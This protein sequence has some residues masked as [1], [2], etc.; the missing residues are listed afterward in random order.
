MAVDV[1]AKNIRAKSP[2][3]IPILWQLL[4]T[5]A[6][7]AVGAI[8]AI[9]I[10][11]YRV[12][13]DSLR[14]QAL[15]QLETV[16]DNKVRE[17]QRYLTNL[18]D[19]IVSLARNPSTALA[20]KQFAGATRDLDNDAL[21]DPEHLRFHI[22][23]LKQFL[24]QNVD[25]S[26]KKAG[27]ASAW[28]PTQRSAVYLQS[29]YI[30]NNPNPRGK[31]LLLESA[32][33]STRYSS[34]HSVWQPVFS[35]TI[36]RFH[37]EDLY[38]I[39][40][41][42][43]RVVYSVGKNPDFQANLADGVFADSPLGRL[44]RRL[45][46]EARE[47]DYLIADF[48]PYVIANGKAAAFAGAPIFENG[49]KTG[50]LVVQWSIDEIN[51][52]MTADGQWQSA[53]LGKTGE[54][55]IVGRAPND[56]LMRSE[57][58][59]VSDLLANNTAVATLH[60]AVLAQKIETE[61]V[62]GEATKKGHVGLY[63]GYT[64]MPV[65]GA[66]APLTG[67]PGLDWLVVA[68]ISE[69]EALEPVAHLRSLTLWLAAALIGSFLVVALIVSASISRPARAMASVVEELQKGNHR[70]RVNVKAYNELG[71][72]AAGLNQ[73]L[74]E[75]VDTLVKSEEEHRRLQK[76][77]RDLLTV[78]AAA[79]DGDFTQ[80]AVVGSGSLGNLADALNLMFENVGALIHHL[81]GVSSRVVEAATQI[82]TSSDHLAEG[83]A[84]QTEDITTTTAA[85]HGMTVKI[86][87]V[88][89]DAKIATEAARQTE[90]VAQ[91]GGDV[92]KRVT[93]G[94]DALQ[95]NT[96]ASA[97]KIKRLGERSME[98]STITATIQKISAQTNMLALNAAIEASRAG[99]HGLGFTVVADE[100]RKLA[101]QTEDATRE[102]AELIA[103]IQ[104]ETN[105]A[106]GGIE[107]Q[108]GYVEEQTHLV[109]E[110]GGSLKNI[111]KTS[112]QSAQLIS[113]ISRATIEQAQ[114]AAAVN[115]AMQRISQV[116]RE[117]QSVSEQQQQSAA[118]LNDV[119][120]ELDTQ[121]GLFRVPEGSTPVEKDSP[122]PATP[123]GA[124]TGNGHAV[125]H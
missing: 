19:Q 70:A 58:R 64:A 20:V 35:N 69:A 8:A 108:A 12:A 3:R 74:S 110:A 119:A 47:G 104:A 27:A 65:L 86:Q 44:F 120:T 30:A 114:S 21:T 43:G 16:R 75:R 83:G 73:A 62:V 116:A 60:T 117:T 32:K 36:A 81:H 42:S 102:I 11:S 2:L 46:T 72:L 98:I 18:E 113:E 85:V 103:S 94:M 97:V 34:Y 125:A 10:V 49:Q 95:K 68:E 24:Q 88:Q 59:F 78:V 31:R 17:L 67:V 99:E 55:Y 76:E 77:I 71:V 80:R 87:S 25:S 96:R 9:S 28:L 53:G 45:Q 7:L 115:D 40:S 54:A 92:V 41:A 63:N 79:S 121:I 93:A 109:L 61:A 37:F 124:G 26:N 14:Q 106:V 105:D 107:R 13:S 39:D 100:V 22:E 15:K 38:L 89:D 52:L 1:R 122:T 91:Q 111:L 118:G 50:V 5:F 33:D 51:S 84:R 6:P 90:E 4:L 56:L 23:S 82:R 66:S 29:V 48:A 112:A 101:E 57:S 123:P